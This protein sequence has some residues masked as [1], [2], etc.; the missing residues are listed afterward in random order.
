MDS[1]AGSTPREF[2]EQIIKTLRLVVC[3]SQIYAIMVASCREA[4]MR[5]DGDERIDGETEVLNSDYTTCH[6]TAVYAY[7]DKL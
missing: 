2:A 4:K 1:S 6:S 5:T 7:P 3:L